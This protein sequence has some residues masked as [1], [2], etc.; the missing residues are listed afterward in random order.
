MQPD[1]Y[2]GI[3]TLWE[4]LR[5]LACGGVYWIATGQQAEAVAL[6][7]RTLLSQSPTARAALIA[8]ADDP[9]ALL[10]A[11]LPAQGP[12]TLLLFR[13]PASWRALQAMTL[14]VSRVSEANGALWLLLAAETW[15]RQADAATMEAW[16]RQLCAWCAAHRQTLLILSD[17]TMDDPLYA[18]LLRHYRRLAG[19]AALR[20][21]GDG[22]L[23]DVA[24][25]DD[26]QAIHG[27]QQIPLQRH[28][29]G[30]RALP[31]PSAAPQ[32]HADEQLVLAQRDFLGETPPLSE[33][34]QLFE[35]NAALSRAAQHAQAATLIFCLDDN[36]QLQTLARQIHQLRQARGKALKIVVKETRP[37]LRLSDERLLLSCGANRVIPV[38]ATLSHSLTQIEHLQQQ[39]YTRRIPQDITPLIAAATPFALRGWQAWPTFCAAVRQLLANPLIPSDG[40]GVLATLTPTPALRAR[41]ALTLCRPVR[42]GDIVTLVGDQIV[43]FLSFCRLNDL[44]T[45]LSHV[46]ALPVAEVIAHYEAWGADT[47]I[48]QQLERLADQAPPESAATESRS[49]DASGETTPRFVFSASQD[50]LSASAAVMPDSPHAARSPDASKGTAPDPATMNTPNTPPASA[51]TMSDSS[52]SARPPYASENVS[53]DHVTTNLSNAPPASAATTSEPS[54]AARPED[55]SSD[56]MAAAP[57]HTR[58]QTINAV[59]RPQRVT[60]LSAEEDEA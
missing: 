36:S 56:R 25:W 4:E 37:C 23:Y 39:R 40:K 11:S 29:T 42:Q 32:P 18:R 20:V 30:W 43:L 47:Q 59:R 1:F 16:L 60:L 13:L 15:W 5:R 49:P 12:A 58:P 8:M 3:D 2:V 54:H 44:S 24:W 46:F 9:R 45:A 34:W 50:T 38:T 21:D 26:G 52:P 17:T 27:R 31:P 35:D 51:T 33:R 57:S 53:S 7:N 48:A 22:M 19:L 14:D 6:L 28:A 55:I 10:E 41:Q